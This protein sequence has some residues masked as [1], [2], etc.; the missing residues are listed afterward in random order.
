MTKRNVRLIAESAD[1]GCTGKVTLDV[2]IINEKLKENT[3]CALWDSEKRWP[4]LI[5]PDGTVDFG[6]FASNEA[7]IGQTDIYKKTIAIGEY[8]NITSEGEEYT[9]KIK[10]LIDN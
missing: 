5:C 6:G 3:Y 8:F 10:H 9:W 4:M 7:K 2:V 1:H